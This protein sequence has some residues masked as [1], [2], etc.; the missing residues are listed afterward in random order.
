MGS[1]FGVTA[2]L[3]TSFRCGAYFFQVVEITPEDH[4]PTSAPHDR[5]HQLAAYASEI[6]CNVSVLKKII[7]QNPLYNALTVHRNVQGILVNPFEVRNVQVENARSGMV[8]P[9]L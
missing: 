4:L 9:L 5:Q 3:R 6:T 8:Y 1:V 2:S 7:P